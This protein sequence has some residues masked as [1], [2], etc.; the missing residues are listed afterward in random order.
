VEA[1]FSHPSFFNSG[2]EYKPIKKTLLICSHYPLPEIYGGNMRTMNFVRFFHGLG[3]VDISYSHVLPGAQT[4][5]PVFSNEYFLTVRDRRSFKKSLVN[6][7]ITG[8]PVPVYE[9]SRDAYR[10]LLKIIES[11]HY[12][13]IFVRYLYST[14]PLL[15]LKAEYRSQTIIDFDDLL[16]GTLYDSKY[17]SVEGFHKR[18][19]LGLNKTKL[20]SYEK[21]C[22]SFGAS[23]FCSEK[24]RLEIAKGTGNSFVIPNIYYNRLFQSFRFGD[25]FVN[26]NDLLFVGSLNYMPNV[27]GL[28]WFIKT[29][30]PSY[31]EL[32]PDAKLS[33]VG[34]SPN[35]EAQ[36]VCER[37]VDVVLYGNV[38]DVKEY[39]RKCKAVIVPLLS[40]GGTRIKI[41]E[42]AL[43]GRPVLSTPVGA[44]G[45]DFADGSDILFFDN[46]H[47]FCSKYVELTNHSR[48]SSLA[49]NA[50]KK[51]LEKY[52]LATF[53]D[54]M[55]KV[56]NQ[57]SGGTSEKY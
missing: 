28:K 48:Y 53:N 15:D 6:G 39:Y 56:L 49:E 35:R 1:T 23:L 7:F 14:R 32:F 47:D 33:V 27:A 46:A 12:D 50:R 38:P 26:G 41:L 20:V 16:T 4:G 43:A 34:R 42:A 36:D 52:S 40:G 10:S 18:M 57:L 21:K 11:H 19:I 5:N 9:F 17:N 54:A 30:F 37:A 51:A 13:Y 44:E 22:L 55:A 24:D 8:T 2:K 3:S 31:K 29:I 45:L 25:G